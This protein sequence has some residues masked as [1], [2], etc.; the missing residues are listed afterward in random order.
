MRRSQRQATRIPTARCCTKRWIVETGRRHR[1]RF[2]PFNTD[3]WNAQAAVAAAAAATGVDPP[4]RSVSNQNGVVTEVPAK[5]ARVI[6]ACLP[7]AVKYRRR[8]FEQRA[9]MRE[10]C[11][12][13]GVVLPQLPP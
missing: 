12:R 11:R 2:F 4:T 9:M 8:D 7:R 1:P 13:N 5:I 6:D 3:E 10:L